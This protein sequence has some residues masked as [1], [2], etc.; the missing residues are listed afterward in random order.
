MKRRKPLTRKTELRRTGRLKRKGRIK[1]VSDKRRKRNAE[2]RD[3][4][5]GL[6][7]EIGRC[8][9]CMQVKPLDCHEITRGSYARQRA[10]DQRACILVLCRDC[11]NAIDQ[12][13]LT[14]TIARQVA[15]L[16]LRR[17]ADFSLSDVNALLT[18]KLDAADIER[19]S[20]ILQALSAE[21]ESWD[22]PG[23]G[24]V[25]FGADGLEWRKRA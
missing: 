19:E 8:E 6:K 16:K 18:R 11:H 2:V 25:Q 4:R 20:A 14:W 7:E 9:I 15:L 5:Q 21:W 10:L 23:E 12:W 13:P 24:I 1:P 3:F 17:A 22:R